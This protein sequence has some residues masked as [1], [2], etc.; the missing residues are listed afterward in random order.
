MFPDACIIQTHRDPK[1]VIVSNC[2]LYAAGRAIFSNDIDAKSLGRDCLRTWSDALDRMLCFRINWLKE[3]PCAPAGSQFY[4]VYFNKFMNDGLGTVLAIYDHFGLPRPN[5][6]MQV[7][8]LARL[9]VNPTKQ[10]KYQLDDWGLSA[11]QVA[12]SFRRYYDAHDPHL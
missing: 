11:E 3:H 9:A 1:L 12:V 8:M 2:S 4:D 10:H 5:A 7:Q 6:A